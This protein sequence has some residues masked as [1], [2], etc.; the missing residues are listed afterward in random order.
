MTKEL[1]IYWD[2]LNDQKKREIIE[3]FGDNFNWDHFP[4]C[5]L[6]IEIDDEEEKED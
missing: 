6:D 2:D 3:E 4:I 5:T 1:M